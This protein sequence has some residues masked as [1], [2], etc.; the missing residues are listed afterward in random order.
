MALSWLKQR[1]RN[2]VRRAAGISETPP[3]DG[4]DR[5]SPAT[6]AAIE[7]L[8]FDWQR[9]AAT[10]PIC[11]S[12]AGL[13]VFSQME[14]DGLLVALFAAIGTTN[15]IFVD[16]GASD[17]INCNTA[18]LAINLRW[19]GLM[20][21]GSQAFV[22]RGQAFYATHP[23]TV[24][25]PPVIRQSLVKRETINETI[26]DAGFS[27]EIDFL[28]IDIDGNDYWI[29]D[30]LTAVNPRAVM[31][32][33]NMYFEREPVTI[34][35]DAGFVHDH[36]RYRFYGASA[37]A[38]RRLGKRKGY[39]LVGAN[40]YGFNLLFVR[41]DVGRAVLPEVSLASVQQ[42]PRVRRFDGLVETTR[43]FL[44]ERVE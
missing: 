23:D 28:S 10:G 24:L 35:Y 17:G 13:R 36:A 25:F 29:W 16:I 39:R 22:D 27:G 6:K 18:N 19:H 26:R 2:L 44:L 21:E 11:L 40:R 20:L 43:Q 1:T 14:E 5:W 38:F 9:R 33:A 8:A 4:R 32:E 34:P 7:S 31:V 3:D 37:E 42:H 15:R 12:D 30:A 41:D